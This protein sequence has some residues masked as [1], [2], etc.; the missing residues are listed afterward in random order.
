MTTCIQKS[1]PSS[2]GIRYGGDL[3]PKNK[4]EHVLS[5]FLTIDDTMTIL[6]RTFQGLSQDQIVFDKDLM[7]LY[8]EEPEL[9]LI[10]FHYKM[11]PHEDSYQESY[12]DPMETVLQESGLDKD[13]FDI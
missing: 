11:G 12:K 10:R 3:T 6:K 13:C 4:P 7:A 5:H 8:F 9:V 2:K 1:Y